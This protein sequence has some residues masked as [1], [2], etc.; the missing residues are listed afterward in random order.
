[1]ARLGRVVESLPTS[2]IDLAVRARREH[3]TLR[4]STDWLANQLR[5]HD[6]LIR[7]G[8]GA[9][10]Q[11]ST[12]RSNRIYTADGH[13]ERD[14]AQALVE[15]LQPATNFYDV[16]ANFG[17]YSLL[18]ARIVG[19][20]GSVVSFEPLPENCRLVE[21]NARLNNF[22]NIR[23]FG[24]AV[25]AED[26]E[27]RFAVSSD[28]CWG[29]I[30]DTDR[31]HRYPADY[32]GDIT[33]PVGRLDTLMRQNQLPSPD[34]IKMD[35]EGGEVAGLIGA[36]RLLAEQRPI[37]IIELHSTAVPVVSVL[38]QHGYK[39]CLLGSRVPVERADGNCHAVAIHREHE[40]CDSLQERFQAPDF[41]RCERCER[42]DR[43]ATIQ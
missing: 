33:V 17:V 14:V 35:I 16:G 18:A 25:G 13:M 22:T 24:V 39:V 4:R 23:C 20:S 3:P 7:T 34:V 8:I 10:L 1:M 32:V 2:W 36:E 5:Y 29:M 42:C 11:I 41:P 12:G 19:S 43:G 31:H 21:H 40:D 27:A 38:T 28:P 26:G 9:G 15:T 6:S 30:L 37:I